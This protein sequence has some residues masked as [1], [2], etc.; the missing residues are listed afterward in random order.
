MHRQFIKIS[1]IE[2]LFF[3]DFSILRLRQSEP[4]RKMHS[5]RI[6]FH[7]WKIILARCRLVWCSGRSRQGQAVKRAGKKENEGRGMALYEVVRPKFRRRLRWCCNISIH[8]SLSCL[9][10]QKHWDE[11]TSFLLKCLEFLNSV[12]AYVS[13]EYLSY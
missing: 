8:N 11:K 10:T 4:R 12:L 5:I 7:H 2:S 6:I 3:T 13:S 1:L 9:L